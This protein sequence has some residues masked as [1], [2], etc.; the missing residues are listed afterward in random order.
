[1]IVVDDGSTDDTP[2]V[3]DR[4]RK[5]PKIRI[6]EQDNQGAP[7]A[8][9]RGIAVATSRYIGML[10]GDDCWHPQKGEKHVAFLEAHPE[11]DLSYSWCR[12]VDEK[13]IPNGAVYCP[14]EPR[15]TFER[16]FT[17]CEIGPTSSAVFRAAIFDEVGAFDGTLRCA[18]YDQEF[19][20]RIAALRSGNVACIPEILV[21]NRRWSGQL[22]NNW[23]KT[24]HS[25]ESMMSTLEDLY[26]DT[27][28]RLASEARALNRKYL[29]FDALYSGDYLGARQCLSEAWR[30]SPR[31]TLSGRGWLTMAAI[32]LQDLPGG[33]SDHL[34]RLI[35]KRRQG[36]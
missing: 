16:L 29:A 13:G 6:I 14:T 22:T 31:A 34:L 21:D 28:G 3:L 33:I 7:V 10:D 24:A 1:M 23:E 26:P 19:W 27:Y 25:F 11:I 36:S 15:A 18:H 12:E 32:I 5:H 20:L 8:S 30:A 2:R 35:R 4:Y 17:H 9:N